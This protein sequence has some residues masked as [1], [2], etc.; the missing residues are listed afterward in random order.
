M[1]ACTANAQQ[2]SVG[3]AFDPVIAA[4]DGWLCHMLLLVRP[5][6]Y[7]LDTSFYNAQADFAKYYGNYF[8]SIHAV[9]QN[10]KI[11]KLT[12]EAENQTSSGIEN[13]LAAET[14]KVHVLESFFNKDSNIS[15][16]CLQIVWSATKETQTVVHK[17]KFKQMW[18]NSHDV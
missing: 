4:A 12:I 6:N 17:M 14:S 8:S 2:A 9:A 10:T 1:D 3:Y 15:Q 18:K 13:R 16:I 7:N 5:L 11:L